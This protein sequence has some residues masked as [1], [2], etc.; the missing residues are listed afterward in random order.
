MGFVDGMNPH[1]GYFAIWGGVDPWGLAG[2][3][4]IYSS[5]GSGGLTDGHAWIEY[6]SDKGVTSTFGTFQGDK[7]NRKGALPR[8]YDSRRSQHIDDKQVKKLAEHI[9]ETAQKG[10]EAWEYFSPCSGFAADAWEEATGEDLD[11]RNGYGVSNPNTLADSIDEANK[12]DRSKG[13]NSS[14][15]GSSSSSSWR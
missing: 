5:R 8:H 6:T 4:T 9:Q 1:G 2:T 10:D 7:L 3:L 11:D 13:G 14:K 15:C 12:K